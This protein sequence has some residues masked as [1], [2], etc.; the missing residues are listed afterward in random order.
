M[1]DAPLPVAPVL[2]TVHLLAA[3]AF[4]CLAAIA[5]AQ[6][7]PDDAPPRDAKRGDFVSFALGP[8]GG[9]AEVFADR[10]QI[11]VVA[12]TPDGP[13][14]TAGLAAGDTIVA[15]GGRE[16]PPHSRDIDQ[17]DGPMRALGDAIDAC[18]RIGAPLQLT[19]ER[20]DARVPLEVPFVRRG[21]LDP[22]DLRPGSKARRFYDGICEDLLRTRRSDGSWQARTGENAQR[23][24]TALCGLALLGRG[25]PADRTALREVADYLAGPHRRGHTSADMM[26][27]AGLSNWF[28]TMSGVYL[29]E[30]VLATGDDEF[31]P[32][33]QHLCDCMV[34][35]QS[36]EGRYGH[37]IHT[38]YSGRGFN[39]INAHVH[40]LWALA[41]RAGCRIDEAAWDRSLAEIE[42]SVGDNGAV[43]YW[44]L[45]TGYWDASART[46]MM[47]IALSVRGERPTLARRMASYLRG[48]SAR[49]REAH[50]M[51]SIGMIFGTAALRRLDA[52]GWCE[53]LDGWR[54]YLDLMRAPDDSAG[55]VG[56]KRNN[57]GD[58][59]LG[60]EHVA[61][62][63]AGMI[64]ATAEGKLHMCGNRAMRW[65]VD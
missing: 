35:R 47:A 53:H 31:V 40:L 32:T 23:Y 17:L 30:Y 29:S 7:R 14:A 5:N 20:A 65:F 43:R 56:G 50:A 59:Y 62:A 3:T 28:V 45:E 34:R 11:V 8:L 26:Q 33:I 4:T 55:Y 27:P 19:I 60:E 61:N 57:G 37:G 41:E 2:R 63:I 46:G 38:G 6:D 22:C 58:H 39:I 16:L 9:R 42:R 25:D 48:H 64:F 1:P 12:T 51:G 54:W 21:R 49:M 10:P 24:V 15:I 44:T 52:Y 36:P 13:G 18:E